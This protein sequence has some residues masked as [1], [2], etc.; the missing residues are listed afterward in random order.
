[1]KFWKIETKAKS[2]ILD[3][4]KEKKL[5]EKKNKKKGKKGN[6]PKLKKRKH[7]KFGKLQI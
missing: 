5:K 7:V 6:S 4:I 2:N 3:I 1:M